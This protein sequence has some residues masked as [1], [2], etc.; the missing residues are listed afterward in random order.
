MP[1][2]SLVRSARHRLTTR[3]GGTM[4][5]ERASRRLSAYVYGNVLVLAAVAAAPLGYVEDGTA[6]LL[7]LGTGVSTFLA[8]IFADT[9][10]ASAI[11]AERRHVLEELR[12]S[13]PIASSAAVP[14]ALLA[15]ATTDLVSAALA[16]ALSAG[17]IA[18]R[19]SGIPVVAARLRGSAVS[20]RVV[21]AGVVLA[22]VAAVVVAV[23][24]VLTH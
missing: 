18:L 11:R 16:Q 9:V 4:S 6:A 23:K 12:D 3:H 15:V 17:L 20:F 2:P 5:P 19:V 14:A 24:I 22:V 7:V 1:L 10:A 8:H 13:V 21:V